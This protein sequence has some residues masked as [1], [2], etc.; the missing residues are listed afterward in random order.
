ME[1]GMKIRD[2]SGGR[3]VVVRTEQAAEEDREVEEWDDRC[4]MA[5]LG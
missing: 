3:A 5:L 4:F 1:M 2:G